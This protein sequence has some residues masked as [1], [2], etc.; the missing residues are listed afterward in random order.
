METT[1]ISQMQMWESLPRIDPYEGH[2]VE[3]AKRG[4]PATYFLKNV[5]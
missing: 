4:E 5:W 2:M 1:E 3:N